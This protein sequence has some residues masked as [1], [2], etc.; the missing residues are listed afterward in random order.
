MSPI[1]AKS[2]GRSSVAILAAS[3]S[4]GKASLWLNP[5]A[6]SFGGWAMLHGWVIVV[7]SACVGTERLPD[8][9]GHGAVFGP[10]GGFDRGYQ[11]GIDAKGDEDGALRWGVC[12][13]WHGLGRACAHMGLGERAFLLPCVVIHAGRLYHSLLNSVEAGYSDPLLSPV[14]ALRRQADAPI[15]SVFR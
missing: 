15:P 14:H 2:S 6:S 10:G 9:G 4:G 7:L 3:T 5:G 11:V 13:S 1:S 12:G 8:H